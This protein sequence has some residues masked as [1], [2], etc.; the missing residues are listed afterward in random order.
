MERK[1]NGTHQTFSFTAPK[2]KSVHLVGDFTDWTQHPITMSRNK[3]G[4][5]RTSVDMD[6][7]K[8][9]YRFLVDGQWQ[10]DPR[11][12]TREPNPYGSED[13]ILQVA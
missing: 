12:T 4:I 13:A 5:W 11:C 7:G 8:H 6:P 2:A 1:H 9:R 10:D 3:D